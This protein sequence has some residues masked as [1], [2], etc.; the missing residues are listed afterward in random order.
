M[1]ARARRGFGE[2]LSALGF[3]SPKA[4]ALPAGVRVYAVG[5][6]HGCSKLLDQLHEL[7]AADAAPSTAEKRIVYLGDYVD[8][9]PDS[10]GSIERLLHSVPAGLAPVYLKGNHDGALLDFLEDSESYRA[11]RNYGAPATLLSY[12]VRPP[13]Y[14]SLEAFEAAR[15]AL[16]GSI[17]LEHLQFLRNLELSFVLGDYVFVHAGLRP[18]IPIARQQEQDLLWIRDE[19]LSSG[20]TF[21]KFVVHGHSPVPNAT[22]LRNRIPVDSGAYATGVLSCAVL[23]GESCR[24]LEVGR[25]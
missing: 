4:A 5:D 10:K 25:S 20:S 18:G 13:L 17:P 3:G 9:G 12:G 6:I 22:R 15:I 16:S 11:W 8:R 14:D 7:I 1:E 2:F 23:E 19:F 21:E 24:I